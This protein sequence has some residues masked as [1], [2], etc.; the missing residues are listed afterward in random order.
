MS[1]ELQGVCGGQVK[2]NSNRCLASKSMV[3]GS[4]L[5]FKRSVVHKHCRPGIKSHQKC[6]ASN[7][8]VLLKQCHLNCKVNHKLWLKYTQRISGLVDRAVCHFQTFYNNLQ[9]T[10]QCQVNCEVNYTHSPNP[11]WC[12]CGAGV[13]A[14][15][16]QF[17]RH[18]FDSC[19]G[20]FCGSA[21]IKNGWEWMDCCE[22]LNSQQL[23]VDSDSEWMG[24]WEWLSGRM[25]GWE[26]VHS[27][28]HLIS[29]TVIRNECV[30]EW[31]PSLDSRSHQPPIAWN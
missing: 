24:E 8:I 7:V 3:Q 26:W 29:Q 31:I 17:W 14:V 30:K 9:F 15:N 16:Y 13:R 20:R 23:N 10:W 25:D 12:L 19:L 28:S 18:G 27:F 5:L 22:W 2:C 6:Y 11:T 4:V 21:C 1:L